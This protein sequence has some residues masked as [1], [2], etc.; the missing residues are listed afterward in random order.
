M[1]DTLIVGGGIIGL[2]TA[3]YLSQAGASVTLLE[4][5]QVLNDHLGILHQDALGQFQTQVPGGETGIDKD[6]LDA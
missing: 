6:L 1:S 2:L 3:R 5:Q 4:R